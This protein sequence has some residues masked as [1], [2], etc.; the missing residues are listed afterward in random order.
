MS[1]QN[2]MSC[3]TLARAFNLCA[4][5]WRCPP[6]PAVGEAMRYLYLTH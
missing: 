1:W 6:M 5:F 3:G 4:V 2:P